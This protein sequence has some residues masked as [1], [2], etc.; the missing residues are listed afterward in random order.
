MV[1]RIMKKAGEKALETDLA[2]IDPRYL[3]DDVTEIMDVPY[4]EDSLE[5]HKLDIYLKKDGIGKPVLI[6]IHGGGFI[7]EDKAMN[8]LWGHYMAKLGF[9]VFELNVRLCYPDVTVFDQITDID[10][11]VRYVLSS[12]E[13]LGADQDKL[14]IAGHSSGGVLAVSECLLSLDGDMRKAFD[15]QARDYRYK[16]VITDC[17]LMHY[18]KS[19]IA[20]RG[21]RNMVFPKGYNK[22]PRYL[23]LRFESNP[24]IS[25][26]PR[27]ALITNRKDI[28][29][30]MT[31]HFDSVLE[32]NGVTHCL[33]DSGQDGHTGIIFKP[34]TEDNQETLGRIKE[35]LI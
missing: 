19:S 14:F 20:Y 12:L 27:T 2:R 31:Y 29:K 11:A 16:G 24:A 35:Y 17:G 9:V 23:F 4:I 6:D 5:G 15:I 1:D 8:R 32:K 3:A 13:G 25:R 22:D 28:L 30:K 7:S 21:M 18:Y 26:L 33:F 10:A 34:Y